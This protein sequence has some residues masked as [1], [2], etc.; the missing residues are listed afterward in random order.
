MPESGLRAFAERW[1]VLEAALEDEALAARLA[2]PEDPDNFYLFP[3]R[4]LAQEGEAAAHPAVDHTEP[5]VETGVWWDDES[6]DDDV[7][8][9]RSGMGATPVDELEPL[10]WDEIAM[11]PTHW[12]SVSC[13]RSRRRRTLVSKTFVDAGAVEVTVWLEPSQRGKATR[14]LSTLW[15]G[16]GDV[17]DLYGDLGHDDW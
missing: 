15:E 12:P 3:D 16:D 4:A 9:R 6:D 5:V 10:D 14:T 11:R 8:P 7:S 1:P 2:D 17:D 13:S